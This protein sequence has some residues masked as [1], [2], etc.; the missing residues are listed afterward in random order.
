MN[1]YFIYQFYDSTLCLDFDRL[2]LGL[3]ALKLTKSKLVDF[4][5]YQSNETLVI[6]KCNNN[7]FQNTFFLSLYSS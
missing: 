5:H 4:I 6:L 3:L 2:E 1:N 7:G